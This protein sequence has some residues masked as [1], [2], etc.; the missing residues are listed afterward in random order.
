M[1]AREPSTVQFAAR[2]TA[3]VADRLRDRASRDRQSQRQLAERYIDEGLRMDDHPGLVFR[4]GPLGRRAGLAA[5]PDVWEI[6]AA[7]KGVPTRGRGA[8][9]ELAELL[10]LGE[11]Q[12]Q[13]A[14]GYYGEYPEEIDELIRR[15]E[16]EAERAEAA[17]RRQQSAL[18]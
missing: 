3:A 14:L 17:W 7:L 15:N 11:G 6:V 8:I 4:D 18:E 5:G 2:F 16:D 1:S 9:A 12:I 10:D 13:A